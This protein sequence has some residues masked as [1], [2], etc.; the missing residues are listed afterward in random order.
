[1]ARE[2]RFQEWRAL[3]PILPARTARKRDAG[4]HDR[5]VLEGL[6]PMGRAADLGRLP[7]WE[8]MGRALK[9][10]SDQDRQRFLAELNPVLRGCGNYLRTGNAA[11]T[12]VMIDRSVAGR[13]KRL[14]LTRYGR[15]L[16]AGR[17]DAWTR[18][19]FEGHGLYR[20]RGTIRYPGAA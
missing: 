11:H 10:I 2:R 1:M 7:S 18:D 4:V 12:F 17:P 19:W 20:L 6:A 16:G 13:L 15:K 8:A 14:L 5:S 3:P 9:L